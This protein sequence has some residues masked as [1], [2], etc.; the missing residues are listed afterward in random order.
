[1][2]SM[3]HSLSCRECE[4]LEREY[5]L[6]IGEIY[7]VVDGR[8]GTISEKLRELWRWQ[9]ARD[10]VLKVIYKHKRT[11]STTIPIRSGVA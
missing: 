11:Q 9:E 2:P 5:E 10:K 1:M 3:K 6:I 4:R 8:V 7:S